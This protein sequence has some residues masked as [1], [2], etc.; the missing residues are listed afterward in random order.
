[1]LTLEYLKALK[2][3]TIFASGTGLIEHPWF[4][5]AKKLSEGGCLEEDGRHTKVK[6][7]AIRGGIYDWA[8]YHSLDSNFISENYLDSTC[9]LAISDDSISKRGAK[10][11]NGTKIKEFVPCND[12]AFLMY[13]Y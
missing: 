12:E 3:D 8:I 2:P 4:N 10:L 11:R 1:M 5:Q 9:H 7:I 6:W 13:R